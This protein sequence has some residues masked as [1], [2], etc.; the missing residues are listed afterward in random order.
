MKNVTKLIICII[1]PLAVGAISGYATVSGISMW[2]AALN[3]PSFNPPNY[4]FG[5]VWTTLYLLMGISLYMVVR[6]TANDD[7]KRAIALFAVQLA[8][9]FT[10][11]FLFFT[12]HQTGLALI[13]I[14]LLWLSI[15][16]MIWAFYKVNRTAALLQ[17]PYIMWV[18]FASV[19]NAAIWVLN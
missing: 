13:N 5:P 16:G 7:R 14:G 18:T 8:L 6:A 15:A 3:K 2:Y 4:L 19:L 9:N 10:W 11:S 17:I 12:F 1:I